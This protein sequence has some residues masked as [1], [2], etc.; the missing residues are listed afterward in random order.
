M[1]RI[2][3]I[4]FD[5]YREKPTIVADEYILWVLGMPNLLYLS[6]KKI[7]A[8]IWEKYFPKYNHGTDA[9]PPVFEEGK[10]GLTLYISFP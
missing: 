4:S 8:Y 10:D 6:N 2:D 5:N 9:L 1:I 3:C 7:S